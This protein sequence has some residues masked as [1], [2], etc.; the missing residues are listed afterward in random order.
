M[1]TLFS[2][3]KNDYAILLM[4]WADTVLFATLLGFVDNPTDVTSS[5]HLAF[6]ILHVFSEILKNFSYLA[7]GVLACIGIYKFY[8]EKK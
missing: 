7:G 6:D 8:K 2:Q 3:I 5:W 4:K 1:I